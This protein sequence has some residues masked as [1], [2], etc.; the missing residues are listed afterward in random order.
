[1]CI[2]QE[3]WKKTIYFQLVR[4]FSN[5]AGSS[6]SISTEIL[7]EQEFNYISCLFRYA[8][9][10]AEVVGSNPTR[11]I[12]INLVKYGIVLSLCL[13]GSRAKS[14]NIRRRPFVRIAKEIK[15]HKDRRISQYKWISLISTYKT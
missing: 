6:G 8:V 7:G 3:T 13:G 10:S 2:F 14:D 1:V 12:L 9:E 4:L 15:I 11:S 5:K